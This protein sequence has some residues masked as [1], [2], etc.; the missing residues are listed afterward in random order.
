MGERLTPGVEKLTPR[1]ITPM[2]QG[3]ETSCVPTS[4][5]MVF[6]GFGVYISEQALVDRY[7]PNAGLPISAWDP[8]KGVEVGVTNTDTVKG[9]VQII[10]DFGL[11]D[12]LQVDAFMPGL[13]EYTKSPEQKYIVRAEPR[14]LRK[15]RSRFKKGDEYWEFY[16]ALE[17]LLKSGEIGIY[18]ANSRMMRIPKF[19]SQSLVPR[20]AV[21]GFYDELSD[22]IAKGHIIGPHGGMTLHTRALDGSRMERIPHRQDEGGYVIMDPGGYSYATSLQSLVMVDSLGVRGD[23][24]DYLFRVSPREELKPQNYGFR[25]FIQNLSDL[26]P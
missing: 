9:L 14:A 10:G 11:R 25:R 19:G 20:E 8:D 26:I 13:D 1:A 6:S 24:F 3:L 21:N 5:S 12:Q 17:Q 22:F 16:E 4:I 15:Y 2:R 18:T 23:A 7:F